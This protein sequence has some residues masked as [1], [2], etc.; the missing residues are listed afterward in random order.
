MFALVAGTDHRTVPYKWVRAGQA[1]KDP[2]IPMGEGIK[3]R[4]K[5]TCWRIYVIFQCLC[6]CIAFSSV[7]LGE[8]NLGKVEV[9]S[10]GIFGYSVFAVS[11]V[12]LIASGGY[13]V[14]LFKSAVKGFCVIISN[15]LANLC[16]S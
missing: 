11:I 13:T 16:H 6:K 3:Y 5:H 10:Y 7:I 2:R 1:A 14:I 9:T 15:A 4:Q 8:W 12:L